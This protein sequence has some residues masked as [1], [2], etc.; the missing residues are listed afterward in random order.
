M[1]L[2]QTTVT[3]LLS[4]LF[5]LAAVHKLRNWHLLLATLVS[6][7]ATHRVA[8][9]LGASTLAAET[10]T[11]VL[12]AMSR[13]RDL[14]LGVALAL[15]C[16]FNVVILVAIVKASPVSCNCFRVTTTP[17]GWPQFV[18]NSVLI[19][20]AGAAL[21]SGVDSVGVLGPAALILCAGFAAV[22]LLEL[23]FFDDLIGLVRVPQPAVTT[24]GA[25]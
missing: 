15:L 11:P 24:G 19:L 1:E 5:A 23:V 6:L 9:I 4:G 16:A 17:M 20:V 2:F 14:G 18:R 7:G 25:M 12:L 10:F 8:V 21:L 13:A 22:A 3:M